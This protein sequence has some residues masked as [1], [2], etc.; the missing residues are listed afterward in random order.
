MGPPSCPTSWRFLPTT[1]I[2]MISIA[3][4]PDKTTVIAEPG[5]QLKSSQ[6]VSVQS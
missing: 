1:Y 6:K 4:K 3:C 5:Y 2:Y